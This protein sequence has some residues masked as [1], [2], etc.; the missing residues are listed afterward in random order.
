MNRFEKAAYGGSDDG[1]AGLPGVEWERWM[2]GGYPDMLSPTRA[3][4]LTR[5]FADEAAKARAKLTFQSQRYYGDEYSPEE[6]IKRILSPKID[7]DYYDN[8][9][10]YYTLET[11]QNPRSG[12][13]EH[14]RLRSPK[15]APVWND[16]D[17]HPMRRVD[18]TFKKL[19]KMD[20]D[21]KRNGPNLKKAAAF[22]AMMGK[23]AAYATPSNFSAKPAYNPDVLN[24]P[25][26]VPDDPTQGFARFAP[27]NN[28]PAAG[29]FPG[30]SGPSMG[31]PDPMSTAP[32]RG[33]LGAL[34]GGPP[35]GTPA[36][37][38]KQRTPYQKKLTSEEMQ[39]RAW[40]M[41]RKAGKTTEQRLAAMT[42]EQR[43]ARLD[44]ETQYR[45]AER[46]RKSA[47]NEAYQKWYAST[48]SAWNHALQPDHNAMIALGTAGT[49]AMGV[50]ANG[51]IGGGS[52]LGG[53][54][55]DA[56]NL[57]K[58]FLPQ[59]GRTWGQYAGGVGKNLLSYE[60]TGVS[61]AL[62][63]GFAEG[64]ARGLLV[65]AAVAYGTSKLKGM[66]RG[67]P[68]ETPYNAAND[69]YTTYAAGKSQATPGTSIAGEPEATP[70]TRTV[71]EP[72]AAPGTNTVG[73]PQTRPMAGTIPNVPRG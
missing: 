50:G 13:L 35:K 14:L 11:P 20:E 34:I 40:T 1:F 33:P 5:L 69:P 26:P 25:N 36:P 27:I 59:A 30:N 6:A 46:D 18:E 32:A 52:H 73:E 7:P 9:P 67:G 10:N 3:A 44:Q 22:G 12:I 54:G 56:W 43:Q 24:G 31:V 2:D 4:E 23:R 37:F 47:E 57:G 48:P 8:T 49:M 21:D 29:T 41:D 61:K 45:H 68:G 28:P 15:Y 72:Q 51:V 63:T 17:V 53:A 64:G 42:P 65:P 19:E 71:G 66:V 16:D 60:P 62:A 39:E 55:A 70:G 38:M 58:S